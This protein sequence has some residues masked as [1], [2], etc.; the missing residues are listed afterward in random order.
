MLEVTILKT[1][2]A[3]EKE[4]R[5]LLPY[6]SGCDGFSVESALMSE[7][8]ALLGEKNWRL[9]LESG[10]SRS[11]FNREFSENL[12]IRNPVRLGHHPII[13]TYISKMYD[14]LYTSKK[15]IVYLERFSTEEY[16]RLW[17]MMKEGLILVS[18]GLAFISG[19]REDEGLEKCL[20][21]YK[22]K[23]YISYVRDRQIGQR[24]IC[25]EDLLKAS[26]P[27]VEFPPKIE[28]CVQIGFT[29]NPQSFSTVPASVVNLSGEE[30]DTNL[31][32]S[33]YDL[34]SE[35]TVNKDKLLLL[36]KELEKLKVQ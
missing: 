25:A 32:T 29:H 10:M 16:N 24:L 19:G 34:I 3:T 11:R 1:T 18:M 15:P 4:A 12:V 6:I 17:P 28:L 26:Y 27:N 5:K 31:L 13:S 7:S 20:A 30:R 9:F 35:S 36:L 14:Y 22:I 21:G 2:H 33:V 8:D 23:N